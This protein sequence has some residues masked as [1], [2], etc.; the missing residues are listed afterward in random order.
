MKIYTKTGDKGKTSLFSGERVTKYS[1][2]VETYGSV[3][4]MNSYLGAA[5]AQGLDE[6]VKKDICR[7][8]NEIF[9][10]CAD[11]A[12]TTTT[13]KTA[14]IQQEHISELEKNIDSYT[15]E[16]PALTHFILP[17]GSQG[18]TLLH[19]ARSVCRRAERLCVHLS[20][21]EIVSPY[22]PK[23]LNRLSDFLFTAARYA[24]FLAGKEEKAWKK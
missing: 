20:D 22:A 3:D 17:S 7:I 8:M 21:E 4:E 15:S 12:T 10:L 23:Y 16:L 1:L 19:V 2:R 11:L 6:A 24:N 13:E 18:G 5:V 14:F 9:S